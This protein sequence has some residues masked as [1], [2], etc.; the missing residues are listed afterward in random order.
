MQIRKGF[1]IALI[2]AACFCSYFNSLFASFVWDDNFFILSNPFMQSFSFLPQFFIRDFWEIGS[3]TT[4]SQYY[5]P[6]LAV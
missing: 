3:K 4:I 1:I 5:R 2:I 6:L